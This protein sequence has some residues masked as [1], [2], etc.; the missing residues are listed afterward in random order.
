MPLRLVI[1]LAAAVALGLSAATA[2]AVTLDGTVVRVVDGDTVRVVS[3]GFETPVRLIGIDTPETRHPDE[4]VQCFGPQATA[5]AARLLPP[6]RRVRLVT[7]D[8]QATRDRYGRL[9]AYVRTGGGPS[10]NL[11]LVR[12]GFAKVYVYGGVRFRHTGSFL[13]AERAAR[14][15]RRGLW[16]PP[17]MG[18]TDSPAP[19]GTEADRQ[20]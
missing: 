18:D 13:R 16:G 17:C 5:A 14:E 2:G 4:P 11:R 9:L 6:G 8:T 12:G 3:R 19:A 1:P 15:A 7:D 10:V 20:R